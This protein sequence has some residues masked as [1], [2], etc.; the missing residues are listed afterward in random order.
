MI[1]LKFAM[2]LFIFGLVLSRQDDQESPTDVELNRQ[3]K[4]HLLNY[5]TRMQNQISKGVDENSLIYNERFFD[6]KAGI[7]KEIESRSNLDKYYD[8]LR[9]ETFHFKN[10]LHTSPSTSL[11]Q[12]NRNIPDKDD[13]RRF[14][15]HTIE[16]SI[17]KLP[18]RGIVR[19][20]PW[21][22]TYWP[23][24]NGIL[25]VRYGK[26]EK[27]SI[28]K[29]DPMLRKYTYEFKWAESLAR[30]IQP[31]DYRQ[32]MRMD[33]SRFEKYVYDNYSPAE[34]YDLWVGDKTFS[35]TNWNKNNGVAQFTREFGN[36]IPTWFG[37]CHGWA[38][39]TYFFKKPSKSVQVV[40]QDGT[41]ITF[42]PDDIKGLASLYFANLIYKTNFIGGVCRV[43]KPN[44]PRADN[45]TGLWM[46]QMCHALNPGALVLTITNQVGI[47]R[48]DLVIDPLSD[49]E[50]WNQPVDS[51]LLRYY[52]LITNEFFS[53]ANRAKVPIQFIR[54]SKNPFLNFLSRQSDGRTSSVVGVFINI[55]YA[56]ETAQVHGDKPMDDYL[57]TGQFIAALQ[58]DQKDNIIGGEWKYNAHPNFIWHYDTKYPMTGCC[59]RFIKSFNGTFDQ[60]TRY[61]S[62]ESSKKGNV[63]LVVIDYLVDKSY[64][65]DKRRYYDDIDK[66]KNSNITSSPNVTST[67]PRE[68]IRLNEDLMSLLTGLE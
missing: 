9:K 8:I 48:E 36:D 51:Y 20:K 17:H 19:Q 65:L 4:L 27:N 52:N 49:D 29:W 11:L 44:K 5:E 62:I 42:F 32:T 60:N 58:L 54:N 55:T 23:M 41:K 38:P 63:P 12:M 31:D 67:A 66:G 21:S 2:V 45:A 39:A 10:K 64:V 40:A 50:I 43:H 16:Y 30:Y 1:K 35:L 22:G 59:D 68:V 6:Y 33:K 61:W 56:Y 15:N 53:T 47:K 24:R 25:S 46:D 14:F 57:K 28:G 34:K 37:I 13:P 18:Q 7:V 26:N 3:Y